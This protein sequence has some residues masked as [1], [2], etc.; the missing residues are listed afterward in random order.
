[1]VDRVRGLLER[2]HV[3][4]SLTAAAS[5]RIYPLS[6]HAALPIYRNRRVP[7]RRR[8]AARGEPRCHGPR[9]GHH[10]CA[11]RSVHRAHQR[12]ERHPGDRKSTRLNSSHLGISYAVFCLKKKSLP[13]RTQLTTRSP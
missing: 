9:E 5:T 12:A 10:A 2:A 11:N 7:G 3:S 8:D 13:T 4:V 1:P 6:L